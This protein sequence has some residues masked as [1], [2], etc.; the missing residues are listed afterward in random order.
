MAQRIE[1]PTIT[2]PSGTAIV[3][4]QV[5]ALSLR[6]AIVERIEIVVPPGPSGLVGFAIFHSGQQ[7]IPFTAGQWVV[8]DNQRFDW[9]IERFPTGDK[10]QVQAYNTDVYN[11]TLYFFFHLQELGQQTATPQQPILVVPT[12]PAVAEGS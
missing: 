11:H 10:W 5:T 8:A 4:P 6:D 2:V 7:V 9:N 12:G 3:T 1:A